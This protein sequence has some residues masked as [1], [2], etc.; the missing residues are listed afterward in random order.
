MSPRWAE[1]TRGAIALPLAPAPQNLPGFPT[2]M[3]H[4][5]EYHRTPPRPQT[6]RDPVRG[7]VLH[8]PCEPG[9]GAPVP[10]RYCS[11]AQRLLM[12]G[13]RC[14]HCGEVIETGPLVFIGI[15]GR[16]ATIAPPLHT[17]CA[18]AAVRVFPR[19]LSVP[20]AVVTEAADYALYER[21][22]TA[23]DDGRA[24]YTYPRID[25]DG[26]AERGVLDLLVVVPDTRNSIPV[27]H[28]H[29]DA[30]TAADAHGR[31]AG[32]EVAKR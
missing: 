8:C 2:L 25:L 17:A 23:L 19:L 26:N 16:P 14:G 6:W 3:A 13:R 20:N 29:S 10:G 27:A 18:R 22:L 30:V 24:R 5:R 1:L 4:A 15:I 7:D 12:A 21:R 28:W 32:T 31:S 9:A 11:S